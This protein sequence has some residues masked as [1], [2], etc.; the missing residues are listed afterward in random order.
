MGVSPAP[1]VFQGKLT[2][3]LEDLPG[4]YIIADD[5]LI[6]G[7]GE[8][9]EMAHKDHDEKLRLFLNRCRQKNIKLNVDKFKLREKEATYIGHL[10]TA[11]GLRIH[12]EKVCA[13]EQMPKPTDVKSSSE[14]VGYGKLPG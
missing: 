7:Q 3:A 5:V 10:L 6:K 11:D 8:T 1:E 13:I 9:Q 14:A 12:P 4:L 2:L